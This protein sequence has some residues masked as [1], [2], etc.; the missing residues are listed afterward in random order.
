LW[1][2]GTSSLLQIYVPAGSV[3]SY[4]AAPGW[5]EIEIQLI[6]DTDKQDNDDDLDDK[7]EEQTEQIGTKNDEMIVIIIVDVHNFQLE[8]GDD[9]RDGNTGNHGGN[10]GLILFAADFITAV[11]RMHGDTHG[12]IGKQ[13]C[14]QGTVNNQ[15]IDIC[16]RKAR[17]KRKAQ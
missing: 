17:K 13:G 2:E 12:G 10:H 16:N 1:F 6:A 5:S 9:I 11:N 14:S 15:K 3:D 8:I 7:A 4:K